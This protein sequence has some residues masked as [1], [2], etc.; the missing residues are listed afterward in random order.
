[1]SLDIIGAISLPSSFALIALALVGAFSSCVQ[2]LV[3]ALF[4]AIKVGLERYQG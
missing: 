4:S 3:G 2:D 1:M